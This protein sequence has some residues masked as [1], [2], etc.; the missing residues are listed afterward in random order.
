MTITDTSISTPAPTTIDDV[1]RSGGNEFAFVSDIVFTIVTLLITGLFRPS[2]GVM[3]LSVT[4]CV[5]AVMRAM[6]RGGK[7]L[8]P[9]GVFFLAS[10]VFIGGGCYYLSIVDTEVDTGSLRDA[11]ALAMLTTIGISAVLT[12]LSIRW[13]LTWPQ[14]RAGVAS[15]SWQP[16]PQFGLKAVALLLVSQVSVV[17]A[18]FGPVAEAMSIGGVIMLVLWASSRRHHMRWFGDG[19]LLALVAVLPYVW[20]QLTFSGGGRLLIAG[21]SIAAFVGW[22]LMSPSRLQKLLVICCIPLFLAFAGLNRLGHGNDSADDGTSASSVVSSGE[23]LG[24][25]YAPLETWTMMIEPLT[26]EQSAQLGPR[27]GATFLH[28][29]YLPV[30]RQ[31]WDDKPK[32]FGAELTEVFRPELVEKQH[33]MAGLLQGEWYANFGYAGL[34]LMIPVT[35]W[36]LALLDRRHLRLATSGLEDPR[37]WWQ[38]A[39]LVCI[40]SSLADLLWVGTFTMLSRGGLAAVVVAVVGIMSTSR[41]HPAPSVSVRSTGQAT[42]GHVDQPAIP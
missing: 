2:V 30:P 10:G 32:G 28:T 25:V 19:L 36:F 13:R 21:I 38:A 16:P 14:K 5:F 29:L 31:L 15:S 17:Q 11:A 23:G 3:L 39:V 7:Y 26:P 27:Y 24:S 18:I 1:P 12:A 35:G 42:P 40:V 33:S 34:V 37:A 4:S 20:I 8:T 41:R 9:A 6:G 22:N